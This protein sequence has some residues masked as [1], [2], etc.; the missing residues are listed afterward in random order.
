ML[1]EK[2]PNCGAFLPVRQ[3]GVTIRACE[4]CG[5][6]VPGE[7]HVVEVPRLTASRAAVRPPERPAPNLA[8]ISI[9]LGVIGVVV[10][11]GIIGAIVLVAGSVSKGKTSGPSVAPIRAEAEAPIAAAAPAPAEKPEAKALREA[12][13]QA[14]GAASVDLVAL[15]AFAEAKVRELAPD[16]LPILMNCTYVTADGR[17]S[18]TLNNDARCS[19]EYRSPSRVKRPEGTPAGITVSVPCILSFSAG[20]SNMYGDVVEHSWELGDCWRW[21]AVRPPRCTPAEIW[22]RAKA[23]GAPAGAVA[24]LHF[25]ARYRSPYDP[26]DSADEVDRPER[27]T[28]RLEI[29][30][31]SGNDFRLETP[32]DCGQTAPTAAERAVL[33]SIKK[34]T[35]ALVRCAERS[36]GKHDSVEAFEQVWRLTRAGGTSKIAYSDPGVD[37]EGMFS[38]DL[39]GVRAAWADCADALA[40]RIA[41]PA[42]LPEVRLILRVETAGTV[43][44]SPPPFD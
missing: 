22:E 35:P 9:G 20:A 12:I 10:V 37:I 43:T 44:V 28:W 6:K 39:D 11:A 41:L 32:D 19:W 1:A 14:G 7:P 36:R 21:F 42:E 27:G 3:A 4:F 8:G 18:L 31:D 30:N 40:P 34:V 2:C 29:E 24:H 16:A 5:I 23:K 15:G 17:A 13:E 38:G 25:G 26:V 33:T